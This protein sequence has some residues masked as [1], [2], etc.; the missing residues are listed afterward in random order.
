MLRPLIAGL[1]LSL[2]VA[3][4]SADVKQDQ[5]RAKQLYDEGLIHYNLAEYEAAITSWKESYQLSKAPLLLFNIGQ[6]YRLSGD[7]PKATSFYDTYKR[8]QPDPRNKDELAK[9]VAL[10]KDVPKRDVTPVKPPDTN[11]VT[12]DPPVVVPVTPVV[13]DVTPAPSTK[14]AESGGGTRIA[15]LVVV[16]LGVVLGGGG[17]YFALDARKQQ[18]KN[19]GFSGTWGPTQQAIEDKGQRDVKLAW[20][21]G[22]AGVA[23]I[24]VGGV[25][26]VLGGESSESSAVSITP[27]R[28]G[29]HVAWGTTF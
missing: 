20:A 22:G 16:G 3:T 21:L 23:A 17:V 27:T 5:A 2:L 10:C 25:L 7:C 19:D 1:S 28:G 9:A 18:A 14:P 12:P 13:A 4:A 6:A 8:E 11:V 26:Y 15:G 24:V 29:A